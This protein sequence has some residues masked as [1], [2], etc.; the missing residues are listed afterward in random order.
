[1][2]ELASLF[3]AVFLIFAASAGIHSGMA[4][5]TQPLSASAR[6]PNSSECTFSSTSIGLHAARVSARRGATRPAAAA[7]RRRRDEDDAVRWDMTPAKP[8][9]RR[10]ESARVMLRV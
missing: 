9:R 6:L 2:P 10:A 1:M 8:L 4:T 3:V 7:R 5:L